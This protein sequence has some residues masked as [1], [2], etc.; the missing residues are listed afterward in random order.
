MTYPVEAEDIIDSVPQVKDAIFAV[1]NHGFIE[2]IKEGKRLALKDT[3]GPE[4]TVIRSL[5][6]QVQMLLDRNSVLANM[7]N[8]KLSSKEL[9]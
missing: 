8:N 7:Y 9:K 4:F 5:E 3:K 6:D 2:G 1:Y